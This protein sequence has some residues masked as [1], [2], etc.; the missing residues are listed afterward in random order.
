MTT[1]IALTGGG[2]GGHIYPCL[3]VAEVLHEKPDIEL[4]YIGIKGKLEEEL[5]AKKAPYIDF[6]AISKASS[7]PRSKNP[8]KMISWVWEF[9][10]AVNEAKK[11]LTENKIDAVFG[12]GGYAAAPAFAACIQKKI[13]YIIH[14]LDANM[15][16]ANKAFVK[17]AKALTLA[18][19]IPS[20]APKNGEV[21][22]AGNP[23]SKDFLAVD[24]S[25]GS[26]GDI[27]LLITGGSQGSKNINEYIGQI[28]PQLM[29]KSKL[30]VTHVTG[31]KLFDDYVNKYLGGNKDKYPNY[32]VMAYTHEMDKFCRE[33]DI[34][35]CRSGAMTIAEMAAT[36]T[37]PI[38]IPLPWAA[39]D[40]QTANAQSLADEGAAFIL[41]ESETDSKAL[42]NKIYELIT[43]ES[44]LAS[45][46]SKL[47]DFANP[48]SAERLAELI[49]KL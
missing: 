8:F 20:I 12:T 42:L 49:L 11:F 40:H 5:V 27:K 21:L 17:D 35:I 25:N 18:F 26:D 22:L 9:G 28:L 19:N 43:D 48:R 31:M 14:N 39:N 24:S 36:K 30:S 34:A 33:A 32:N 46:K 23:I 10:N 44:K 4:Y 38:F 29:E 6:L 41:K 3:A 47:V 37:V 16:L 2:T 45:M 7:L 1:R 15:G 13:P